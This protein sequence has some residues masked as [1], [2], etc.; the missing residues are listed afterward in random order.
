MSDNLSQDS[1]LTVALNSGALANGTTSATIKT[2]VAINYVIDGRFYSK[3]ITDN[4]T[5][6]YSGPTVYQAP[7][8]VGG[9][10]GAFTGGANGSTRVY[11][12]FLDTS[13]AVS[14]LP[15]PIVDSADLAAGRASLQWPD[16]PNGVCPFGA[17]RIALTAGTTFIPGTTAF[18]ATGVT[19]TYYNLADMPANPL[20]A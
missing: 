15:G 17:I 2:T 4:I 9:I 16:V 3:S 5:I 1:G 6:S 18:G 8:G 13:G 14:I 12:L 19:T 10:N 20:T 11:G 7:T